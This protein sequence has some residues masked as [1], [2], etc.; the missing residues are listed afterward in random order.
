[1]NGFNRKTNF[2]NVLITWAGHVY[3]ESAWRGATQ[4][5][6]VLRL[7]H[8]VSVYQERSGM[9]RYADQRLWMRTA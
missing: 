8:N 3:Q 9:R 7:R 5:E 1:M 6:V 4:L 2:P